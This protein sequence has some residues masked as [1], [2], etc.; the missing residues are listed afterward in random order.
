MATNRIL[1]TESEWM[2]SAVAIVRHFGSCCVNGQSYTL[3]DKRGW[4]LFACSHEAKMLGREKAIEPG[5]P[6]DLVRTDFVP[7]YRILGRDR[8]LEFIKEHP[9]I[10]A[11]GAKRIVNQWKKEGKL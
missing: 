1:Y 3:V 5:E 10:D 6:V 9:D 8:F 4:D 2:N 11:R 7:V